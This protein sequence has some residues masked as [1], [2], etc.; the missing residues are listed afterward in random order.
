MYISKEQVMHAMFLQPA[1]IDAAIVAAGYKDNEKT[2]TASFDGMTNSGTFIYSVTFDDLHTGTEDARIY[3][4]YHKDI[5][6]KKFV[7]LAD[8]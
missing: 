8:F 1:D 2:K 7:L 4:K 3:L 6:T 5:V